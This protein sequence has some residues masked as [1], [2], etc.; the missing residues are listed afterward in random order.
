MSTQQKLAVPFTIF[1]RVL[2]AFRY[3]R[4]VF[5]YICPCEILF[6][7]KIDS[8]FVPDHIRQQQ[9]PQQIRQRHQRV[10]QI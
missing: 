6:S 10:Q 2:R 1:A 3:T 9:K 7:G 5:H 8:G 4:R